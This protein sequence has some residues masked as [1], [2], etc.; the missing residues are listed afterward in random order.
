[1]HAPSVMAALIRY[2]IFWL[3]ALFSTESFS[4]F[5][6]LFIVTMPYCV[7]SAKSPPYLVVQRRVNV[8]P[9]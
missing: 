8:A 5:R 3:S 1:M 9:T 6:T 7:S 4:G 2:W